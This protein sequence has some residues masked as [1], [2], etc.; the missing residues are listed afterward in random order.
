[1]NAKEMRKLTKDYTKKMDR[2]NKRL[3][4]ATAT[5]TAKKGKKRKVA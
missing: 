1:L 3:E 4:E 2:L 5:A